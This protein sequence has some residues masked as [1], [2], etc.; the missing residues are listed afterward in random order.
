MGKPADKRTTTKKLRRLPG[1]FKLHARQMPDTERPPQC[2]TPSL[3]P[4]KPFDMGGRISRP[5]LEMQ[6][7]PASSIFT[8]HTAYRHHLY[9]YPMS[10]DFHSTAHRNIACV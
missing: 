8:P 3:Q 5:T 7:F 4:V 1:H 2:L 9:I 6:E 10:L